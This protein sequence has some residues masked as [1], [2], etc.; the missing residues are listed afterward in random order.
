MDFTRNESDIKLKLKLKA[1]EKK[2]NGQRSRNR[3][4]NLLHLFLLFEYRLKVW[5]FW[6]FWF[7]SKIFKL[8][9]NLQQSSRAKQFI[10]SD[11]WICILCEKF[12][13]IGLL[14]GRRVQ[15]AFFFLLK[16]FK[17]FLFCFVLCALFFCSNDKF[18]CF[19][20]W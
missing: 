4:R 5:L 2:T 14:F 3:N 7:F 9:C 16:C 10:E 12:E 8:T 6:F 13:L 18:F 20:K 15:Y 11:N 1:K 17:Y 19:S